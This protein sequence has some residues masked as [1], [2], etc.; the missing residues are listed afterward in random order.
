MQELQENNI[1]RNIHQ[2]SLFINNDKHFRLCTV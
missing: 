2:M 1:T